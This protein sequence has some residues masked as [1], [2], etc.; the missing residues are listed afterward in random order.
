M[1]LKMARLSQEN[2]PFTKFKK[3]ICKQIQPVIDWR[4][5]YIC[6]C[7]G[8]LMRHWWINR[9]ARQMFHLSVS[10]VCKA[11]FSFD[12]SS[13]SF[14]DLVGKKFSVSCSLVG[15]RVVRKKH[16]QSV[17]LEEVHLSLGN[18]LRSA[19]HVLNIIT[20]P[21]WAKKKHCKCEEE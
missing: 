2:G 14:M 9:E 20:N 17:L 6:L 19:A 7:N 13:V 10:L 8:F 21:T 15:Q 11:G 1:C 5:V 4:L 18:G 16:F 3:Q 12:W